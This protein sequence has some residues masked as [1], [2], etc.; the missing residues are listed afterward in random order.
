MVALIKLLSVASGPDWHAPDVVIK[1]LWIIALLTMTVGNVL[2]LMQSNIKRVFAY[3]SVAH[4]GY[5]LVALTALIAAFGLKDAADIQTKALAGVLFYL[6][7]YGVMNTGSV[8]RFDDAPRPNRHTRPSRRRWPSAP[9]RG[10][11]RNI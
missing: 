1:L 5:M 7:A 10:L 2:G 9:D 6:C 4:S 3:S 8:R 11:R